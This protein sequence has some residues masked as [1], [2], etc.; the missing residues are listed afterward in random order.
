M[1]KRPNTLY[2]LAARVY[3]AGGGELHYSK[4]QPVDEGTRT[5]FEP[6][7]G[8]NFRPFSSATPGDTEDAFR[9]VYPDGSQEIFVPYD[10]S[11]VSNPSARF[12][13]SERI[14]T[15]G[16]TNRYV[17]ETS[18]QGTTL[19]L[20]GMIDYDGAANTIVYTNNDLIASVQD[21]Y[22]GSAHFTYN[23]STWI[24]SITDADGMTSTFRYDSSGWI[25]N[26]ITPYGT[27]SF[28]YYSNLTN[29]TLGNTGGHDRINR[30]VRV[31][32]PNGG[33]QL[34]MYRFDS[35]SL[36]PTSIPANQIPISPF[37][38]LDKAGDSG[39]TNIYTAF[40]YRN[41]FHWGQKQYPLVNQTVTNMT[42]SDYKL[43]RIKHWLEDTNAL[44]T[45]GTLSIE[46]DPSPDGVQDGLTTWYDYAQKTGWH[47]QG[48]STRV[49]LVARQLP[50]GETSYIRYLYNQDGM[51]TNL[52]TTYTQTNGVT[53]TRTA[54]WTYDSN[55]T[56]YFWR[57][58]GTTFAS[59]SITS[60][61]ILRTFQD[62][63]GG[64]QKFAGHEKFANSMIYYISP[65]PFPPGP[66]DT[67]TLVWQ[68]TW[69]EPRYWTNAL[70]EL[71]TLSYDAKRR[72]SSIAMPAGGTALLNWNGTTG[73]L[74]STVD[75]WGGTNILTWSNGLVR[76]IADGRGLTRT[77]T[78]DNLQRIKQIDYS[79]D[80]TFPFLPFYGPT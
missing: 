40:S 37:N 59:N 32:E 48:L 16:S 38:T 14:N 7:R 4:G 15:F 78:W 77:F 51:V 68:G 8:I 27:N 22:G 67:N 65:V 49:G 66:Q 36:V 44:Y 61:N 20:A 10:V 21:P 45:T 43:A 71:T 3:L 72:V 11:A 9:L 34:F 50:G 47:Q 46:R 74:D 30:S 12:R 57:Q 29:T 42:A 41:S 39:N 62:F 18:N 75:S 54:S 64:I 73:L 63:D 56:W 35:P 31:T 53:G 19:R 76:T 26:M 33:K 52:T 17:Y 1:D 5:R 80:N 60:H 25:T 28:E 69:T 24:S 55:T 13:L 70:Q 58:N 2:H 23:S 79:S 6:V